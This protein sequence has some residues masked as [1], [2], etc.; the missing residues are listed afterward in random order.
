MNILQINTINGRNSQ[1]LFWV[2]KNNTTLCQ[3]K[4]GKLKCHKILLYI[5]CFCALLLFCG[6]RAYLFSTDKKS[7]CIFSIQNNYYEFLESDSVNLQSIYHSFFKMP[8]CGAF[9]CASGM[10]GNTQFC[11]MQM[12]LDL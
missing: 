10:V 12:A 3:A 7:C 1:Q 11:G 8:D 5:L 6:I 9:Y 4:V 2:K